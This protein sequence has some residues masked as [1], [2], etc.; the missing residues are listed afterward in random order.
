MSSFWAL[1][2]LSQGL[3]RLCADLENGAWER[4]YADL[5]DRAELDCGYR[6]VVVE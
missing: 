2:D 5:C 6:L 1:G 4:R 3:R